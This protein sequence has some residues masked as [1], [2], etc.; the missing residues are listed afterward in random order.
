V[1]PGDSR[2]GHPQV[3]H[4]VKPSAMGDQRGEHH[5]IL[6]S[7]GRA[8]HPYPMLVARFSRRV[9]HRKP[10]A[11]RR[12]PF[13]SPALMWLLACVGW[14]S[15]A[16]GLFP[17]R[18]LNDPSVRLI[19]LWRLA[20]EAWAYRGGHAATIHRGPRRRAGTGPLSLA[21]QDAE[22]SRSRRPIRS[23]PGS[24]IRR[25]AEHSY[26]RSSA[27][28]RITPPS[29]TR[30]ALDACSGAASFEGII[31]PALETAHAFCW[32]DSRI[33]PTLAA[34]HGGV[35]QPLSGAATRM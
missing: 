17:I 8:P 21:A 3:R 6:G 24:T 10:R 9:R 4:H 18:S 16:M 32:L 7:V 28:Y 30:R 11:V 25:R 15:N 31:P 13:R 34:G 27:G 19:W 5:Y 12:G 33:C 35:I 1:Q 14:R 20:G 2:H 29:P 22:G 23:A 26:P